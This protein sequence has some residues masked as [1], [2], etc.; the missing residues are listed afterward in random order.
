MG[1]M[2]WPI[3]VAEELEDAK[4]KDELRANVDYESL[5]SAQR[6]YKAV[7]LRTPGVLRAMFQLMSPSL[8]KGR[9]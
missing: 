8:T 3:N 1:A 7:I 5:L 4:L 9:R 2:T 6:D